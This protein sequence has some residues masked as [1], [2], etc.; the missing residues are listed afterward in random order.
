M[1]KAK[2]EKHLKYAK[3]SL[4]FWRE[5]YVSACRDK[6]PTMDIKGL[7]LADGFETLREMKKAD[8]IAEINDA[9]RRMANAQRIA[10]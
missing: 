8:A 5:A 7:Y 1:T 6:N 3:E 10:L 2:A 9:K 4:E